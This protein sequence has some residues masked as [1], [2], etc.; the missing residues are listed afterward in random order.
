MGTTTLVFY[1]YDLC[2]KSGRAGY[3]MA[4]SNML[5]LL[6]LITVVAQ[7]KMMR[8]DASEI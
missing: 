2:F 1:V 8:K 4:V 5:F 3:A 6:I 7:R